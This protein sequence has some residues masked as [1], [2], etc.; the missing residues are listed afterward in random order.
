[1]S[2]A[3]LSSWQ[4]NANFILGGGLISLILVLAILAPWIAPYDPNLLSLE[5]SLLPP[6]AGH[7][8]GTDKS[9]ADVLSILLHGTRLS[10]EIGVTATI[11]CV[12]IGLVLGSIAG[13][14]GGWLDTTLMRFLDII[15]AF[16]GIILAIAIATVMGASKANVIFALTFTGWAGYTRLVRGEVRALKEREYVQAAQAMGMKTSRIIVL[17][18]WPNLVSPVLVA[19]TFGIAGCILAES[20]LSF[21]GIGVPPGTPSWGA[22][23]DQG[24]DV[25][26]DAPHISTFPGLAIMITILA[27]NF[28][29]EGLRERL[30]PKG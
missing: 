17:H 13:Y 19:A 10:F 30:D 14:F 23:L 26:L 16:P 25:L 15:F 4:K 2:R 3:H 29:G 7:W 9:G 6:S 27:F 24:R 22:L 11:I 1:M 18:I 8:L 21:L 5:D 20:S 28:L 12:F